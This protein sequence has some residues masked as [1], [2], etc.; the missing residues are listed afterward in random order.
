MIEKIVKDYLKRKLGI[1][2]LLEKPKNK[3]DEYVLLD[4]T[5]SS[6]K[7]QIN[8]ATFVLQSCAKSL[9]KAAMLN[10]NVK[11]AMDEM[12]MK[13]DVFSAKLNTDY[14]FTD[15]ETKEYRYKAVYDIT[16]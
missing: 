15:P 7:N 6:R 5:G 3:V 12:P 1:P 14:S 11:A 8:S 10:E 9:E 16:Y 2:V 13:C 4:K